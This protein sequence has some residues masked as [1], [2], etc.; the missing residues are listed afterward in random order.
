MAIS[1][2]W[3]CKQVDYYPSHGDESDVVYNVHWRLKGVDSENDSEGNPYSAEVYGSQSLDVSDLSSFV[4]YADLTESVVQGWV[5][6]AIGEDEVA[7][8]KS[9]LDAQI[10]ELKSPSSV[11]GIIGS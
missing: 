10:A 5:E 7:N 4:A 3:N 11:S 2:E 6:A 1:Y 8:L 9:N